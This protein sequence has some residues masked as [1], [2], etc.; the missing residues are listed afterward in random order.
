MT[1][2]FPQTNRSPRCSTAGG[3]G[4]FDLNAKLE[5]PGRRN[6][7]R[8]FSARTEGIS[9]DPRHAVKPWGQ[10]M[11]L[12]AW[13]ALALLVLGSAGGGSV[14]AFAAGAAADQPVT[15]SIGATAIGAYC[16]FFVRYDRSQDTPTPQV[17]SA[18]KMAAGDKTRSIALIAGVSEYPNSSSPTLHAA[19]VDIDNLQRFAEHQ[20]FDE[21]IVVREADVNVD[22]LQYFFQAYIPS[23]A[24]SFSKSRVLFAYSGHGVPL[25]SP[26]TKGFLVL[27][28]ATD[29][30][31]R[32]HLLSLGILKAY[33]SELAPQTYHFLALINA[34][35][36]GDMFGLVQAGENIWDTA[37]P[38]GSA[39]TAGTPDELVYSL[40]SKTDGSLFFDTLIRGIEVGD[41]ASTFRT[42]DA[43]GK[44][45]VQKRDVVRLGDLWRYLFDTIDVVEQQ[46]GKEYTK[47]WQGS[48]YAPPLTSQ[49]GFFFLSGQPKPV[50]FGVNVEAPSGP[51]SSVP[52]RPEIKVFN[53]PDEYT[54]KGIDLS[55]FVGSVDWKKVR[56]SH[57]G[58]GGPIGFAYM[59]ATQGADRADRLFLDNWAGAKSAGIVRGAYHVF[60]LCQPASQQLS[61]VL[62][63]VPNEADALP[64][65][66]DIEYYPSNSG[67]WFERQYA[68]YQ[69]AGVQQVQLSLRELVRGIVE[70][71]GKSP[72][73]FGSKSVVLDILK[74][75][76]N[77]LPIWLHDYRANGG[78]DLPGDNPWTL[79]Q[80][81]DRLKVAGVEGNVDANAFFGTSQDFE[82]F[83]SKGGNLARDRAIKH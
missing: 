63:K 19:K 24:Q 75:D 7:D 15:C 29:A 79:W 74:S 61:N 42:S 26:N 21:I 51:V 4:F 39:L 73:L 2:G 55:Q 11:A 67:G 76:F 28:D 23:V 81:S 37:K 47:P 1:L 33:L 9:G 48:V 27:R 44:V 35:Y 14:T 62:S 16:R 17:A 34:C 83:R 45:T 10:K 40:G 3:L 22:T 60:D 43:S 77:D 46:S 70:K 64:V 66:I 13:L 36:G 30:N 57:L 72:I 56:E 80:Y 58:L 8:R 38:G 78:T 54:V 59:R 6:F 5:L 32:A 25:T 31:D 53:Q 82:E 68:C 18:L 71:Y 65:G 69:S 41:A 52:G 50:S 12:V 49:G 20:G